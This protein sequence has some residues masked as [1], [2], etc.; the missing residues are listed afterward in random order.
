MNPKTMAIIEAICCEHLSE[1][2]ASMVF[3]CSVE[4]IHA[5]IFEA[6]Q[7]SGNKRHDLW[8]LLG[9]PKIEKFKLQKIILSMG[10]SAKVFID[11]VEARNQYFRRNQV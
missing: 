11:R 1:I 7:V 3:G 6:M 9:T 5:A 8:Q 4:K 10:V 2:E